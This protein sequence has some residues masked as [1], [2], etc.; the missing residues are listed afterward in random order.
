MLLIAGLL[1]ASDRTHRA[2]GFGLLVGA[3]VALIIEVGVIAHI[4]GNLVP[5][6]A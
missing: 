1:I 3:P 5:P 2:F 4:I 6:D